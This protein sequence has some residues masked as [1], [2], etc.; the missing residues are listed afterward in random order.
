MHFVFLYENITMKPAEIVLRG[1]GEG[2]REN[3]GEGKSN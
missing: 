3:D 1:R 2:M